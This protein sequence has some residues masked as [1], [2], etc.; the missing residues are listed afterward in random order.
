MYQAPFFISKRGDIMAERM[1]FEKRYMNML[2][3]MPGIYIETDP[4]GII[5]ECS[6]SA[7]VLFGVKRE[8]LRGSDIA[9]R[10]TTETDAAFFTDCLSGAKQISGYEFTAADINGNE[11]ILR[12][13]SLCEVSDGVFAFISSDV[14]DESEQE[15]QSRLTSEELEMKL[16]ERTREMTRAYNELDNFSAIIAHEFKAPIRAIRLYSNII[17]DELD[18][19]LSRDAED[20]LC[21]INEY[22][23][24]SLDLIKNLLE[25]SRL[26][27]R[28]PEHSQV[29]MNK[30]VEGCLNDLRVIHSEADIRVNTALL[31]VVSGD[32]F[33]LRHAVYNILDNSLKYSSVREYTDIDISC[34]T[35]GDMYEF[36]FKDNGVGFDMPGSA[37]PFTMFSRLH[38]SDEFKG[39]GVG[40]AAVRSIVEKHGGRVCISSEPDKGCL[41][42]I[43]IKK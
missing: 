23:D 24:K 40:L 35:V 34:R 28:I 11:I 41:V 5:L 19:T 18:S 36:S 1:N 9:E 38:T 15:E 27:A 4:H 20:A 6:R 31:P 2:E 10:F 7:S 25:F 21:K 43:S 32:E 26:K 30:L 12:G 39:T 13:I 3:N 42:V 17:A 29:D 8:E 33:L 14:T 37:D 22:C 16:L